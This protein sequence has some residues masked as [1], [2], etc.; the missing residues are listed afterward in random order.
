MSWHSAFAQ[1]LGIVEHHEDR[2]GHSRNRRDQPDDVGNA[3]SSSRDR[4]E[5]FRL[6]A[7]HPIERD[8]EVREE[9]GRVVVSIVDRQPRHSP[10][11]QPRELRQQRRLAIPGWRDHRDQWDRIG[12]RQRI[13]KRTP[14]DHPRTC[15][16]H[17]QLGRVEVEADA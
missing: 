16:W 1:Q 10:R 2:L 3:D 5:H 13:E 4:A 8:C 6:D 12:P 11:P 7:L 9:D 14:G 15:L 17:Q